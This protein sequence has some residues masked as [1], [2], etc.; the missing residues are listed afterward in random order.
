M[1]N[2]TT[3]QLGPLPVAEIVGGVLRW[4]IPEPDYTLAQQYLRGVHL[5]Y[6]QAAIDAAVAAE[7]ERWKSALTPVMFADFKC[8]HQNA[9]AELPEVAAW[10]IQN[11]RDRLAEYEGPNKC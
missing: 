2:K 10:V 6:D 9:D 7:R 11:L 4:H 3:D 1:N 8:W 5:L